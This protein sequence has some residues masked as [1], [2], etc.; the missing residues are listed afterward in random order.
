MGQPR[1]W[2]HKTEI[3]ALGFSRAHSQN[4]W[5]PTK[6][7]C[8]SLCRAIYIFPPFSTWT[9]RRPKWGHSGRAYF[10]NSKCGMENNVVKVLGRA[11]IFSSIPLLLRLH[12]VFSDFLLSSLPF[13]TN[14]QISPI[15]YQDSLQQRAT[16]TVEEP[17][18]NMKLSVIWDCRH[19]LDFWICH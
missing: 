6:K 5:K 10:M 16:V 17:E 8:Q 1:D 13:W 12:K 3:S 18:K 15:K 19:E 9:T 7:I 2:S 11:C 4:S 14:K